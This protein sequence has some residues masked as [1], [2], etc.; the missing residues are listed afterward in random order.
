MSN[1]RDLKSSDIT[2]ESAFLNRRFFIKTGIWAG[3]TLATAGL[4]RAFRPPTIS[5]AFG[6]GQPSQPL[7]TV[8]EGT[9]MDDGVV[10][11]TL[12]ADEHPNPFNDITH[13]NN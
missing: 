2:P 10:N 11:T 3:T 12:P 9:V 1:N 8:P 5:D 4:Y 6:Q 13:Y 7:V